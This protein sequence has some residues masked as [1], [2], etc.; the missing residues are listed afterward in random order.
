MK[1]ISFSSALIAKSLFIKIH[2]DPRTF[3]YRKMIFAPFRRS[4]PPKVNDFLWKLDTF[5]SP[6]APTHTSSPTHTQHSATHRGV[7]SANTRTIF[8]EYRRRRICGST[9]SRKVAF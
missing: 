3:S 1:I 4:S 5:P 9:P 7:I 2:I 8:V 6:P